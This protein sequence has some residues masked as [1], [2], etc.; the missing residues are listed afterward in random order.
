MAAA[1]LLASAML[2]C[3]AC[4]PG[5]GGATDRLHHCASGEGPLDAY[6]GT[7]SV[8][9]NPAVPAG[10]Q[11]PLKLV[12]AAALRRDPAPD[13]LFVVLGGPGDGAA[14]SA[15]RLLPLFKRFQTDRDIVFVDQ[16]GTGE[17]NALDC[18]PQEVDR[19]LADVVEQ[20]LEPWASCLA[21][22]H[23]DV[24]FYTT[25]YATDDLDQVRRYLGYPH[26][27]IWAA[28]YGTRFALVF[29][30]RHPDA[31]RSL[32]LDSAAP[33][34]APA[35]LYWPRDAQRALDRLIADCGRDA[36]CQVHFPGLAATLG[37]ALERAAARPTV[38]LVD[39]RTGRAFEGRVNRELIAGV[40]LG[41]LY[42]P[43]SAAQLPL[44]LRDAADG[45]FQGLVSIELEAPLVTGAFMSVY[46]SEDAPRFTRADALR[47]SAGTFLGTTALDTVFKP[48]AIWPRGEIVPYVPVR[49]QVPVLVLSGAEDPIAPPEWGAKIVATLPNA[50]QIEVP[51]TGHLTTPHGCVPLLIDT[52]LKSSGAGALDT[53]CLDGLRRPPFLTGLTAGNE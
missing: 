50:R 44:L 27:N 7:L 39:P 5:P 33:P 35:P 15:G 30:A 48:C 11:I 22:L 53:R 34:D 49:S 31:V 47:E 52:F 51:A 36:S 23:A 8:P 25:S 41:L 17:S 38:H 37:T 46:C 43:T 24:R 2:A 6:C 29:L 26:I 10:R 1:S 42:S 40:I 3:T 13:P 16:R 19:T 12:V 18:F 21:K 20:P 45:D 9:E 32:V 14:S 4:V 28:S